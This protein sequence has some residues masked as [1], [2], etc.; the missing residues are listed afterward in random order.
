MLEECEKCGSI[1]IEW[2]SFNSCFRCLERNCQNKWTV[3][4]KGP[5][6]YDDI[7]NEYLK[8]SLPWQSSIPY[9]DEGAAKNND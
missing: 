2:N 9:A 5:K 4:P 6:K 3:W 1:F 8:V 7:K